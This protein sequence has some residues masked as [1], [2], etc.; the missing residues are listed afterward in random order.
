MIM[1]QSVRFQQKF[2]SKIYAVVH[3]KNAINPELNIVRLRRAP[4][5]TLLT[6][7]GTFWI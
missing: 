6:G 4:R 3:R 1:T 2:V 7:Y 5:P